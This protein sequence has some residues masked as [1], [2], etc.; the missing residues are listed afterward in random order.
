VPERGTGGLAKATRFLAGSAGANMSV[1]HAATQR[2]LWAG[3]IDLAHS[4]N[5]T[6]DPA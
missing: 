4:G 3:S 5:A 1:L 2:L 6:A